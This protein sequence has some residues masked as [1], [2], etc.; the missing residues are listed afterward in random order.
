MKIEKRKPSYYSLLLVFIIMTFNSF[1]MG[2]N[3]IDKSDGAL[4]YFLFFLGV[5][6]LIFLTILVF[7][8]NHKR[9][10]KTD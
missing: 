5:I 9:W 7:S 3:N 6:S 2:Y 10:L 4:G 8:R 1:F